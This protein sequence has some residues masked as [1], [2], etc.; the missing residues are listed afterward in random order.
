M[1]PGETY[2]ICHAY[3][4]QL[5]HALYKGYIRRDKPFVDYLMITTTAG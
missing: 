5:R 3:S 1:P 4:V 2:L